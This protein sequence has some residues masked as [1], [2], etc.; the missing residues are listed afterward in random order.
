MAAA[1]EGGLEVAVSLH[2]E[3]ET[4]TEWSLGCWRLSPKPTQFFIN[5]AQF[6]RNV[7]TGETWAEAVTKELHSDGPRASPR[8]LHASPQGLCRGLPPAFRHRRGCF[9]FLHLTRQPEI[10]FSFFLKSP[11]IA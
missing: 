8:P 7:Q 1:A 2:S 10:K 6:G 11:K 3:G 4:G 9:Y 5:K